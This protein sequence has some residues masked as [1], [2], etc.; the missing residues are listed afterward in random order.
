VTA[1]G[2]Y[3]LCINGCSSEYGKQATIKY[4]YIHVQAEQVLIDKYGYIQ[5][6]ILYTSI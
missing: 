6:N 2:T 4:G 3:G 5:P 1:Q